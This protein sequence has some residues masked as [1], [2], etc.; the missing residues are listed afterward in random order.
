MLPSAPEERFR[1]LQSDAV[2][3]LAASLEIGIQTV[4]KAGS[5]GKGCSTIS[6]PSTSDQSVRVLLL[7]AIIFIGRRWLVIRIE[8]SESTI[9]GRIRYH[10]IEP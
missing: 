4:G 5:V 8:S 10:R 7:S 3:Y 9:Q 6:V 1:Q 2:G